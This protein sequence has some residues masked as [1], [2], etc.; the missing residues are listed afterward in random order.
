MATATKTGGHLLREARLSAGLTRAELASLVGCSYSMLGNIE[1]GAVP[2]RS[3]VLARAWAAIDSAKNESS[4]VS[5]PGST[6]GT[7]TADLDGTL[8]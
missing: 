3:A 6:E 8:A 4:P 5:K 7:T 1:Q 2:Q